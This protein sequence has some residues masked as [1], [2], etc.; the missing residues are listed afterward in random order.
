MVCRQSTHTSQFRDLTQFAFTAWPDHGVPSTT[1]EL[2]DFRFVASQPTVSPS[3]LT[4]QERGA[5]AVDAG[6]GPSRCALQCWRRPHGHLYC[7]RP[8]S[9][10]TSL[11]FDS[12]VS[13]GYRQRQVRAPDGYR[14]GL[15]RG[16]QL[17]GPVPGEHLFGPRQGL[18][19]LPD[20]LACVR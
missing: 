2:L 11:R 15:A 3:M 14:D 18:P 12:Q 10:S 5:Q 16:S 8:V 1:Q 17:H 19:C 6:E 7:H 9:G 20:T 4:R 13:R